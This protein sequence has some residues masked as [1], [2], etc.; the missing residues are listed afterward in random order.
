MSLA[1]LRQRDRDVTPT[2]HDWVQQPDLSTRLVH[3]GSQYL[4][5]I[6]APAA[7]SLVLEQESI[8][9]VS[10]MAPALIHQSNASTHSPPSLH[11][12]CTEATPTETSVSTGLAGHLA[13]YQ[14]LEEGHEG[15]LEMPH[16]NGRAPVFECAFWFLDC[17]YISR[18][19]EEWER[20]CLSHF[21]GEEPP[22]KVQCPLCDWTAHACEGGGHAAWAARM[23]HV[24][25]AHVM[26]GQTLRTSRP[27]F[28]LFEY[29][30]QQRLID[31]EDLKELKAGNHN[32]TRPPGNFVEMG[33][34]RRERGGRPH[35]TQHVRMTRQS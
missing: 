8:K 15:I 30:W 32:L 4:H 6:Q 18:N 1:A 19:Q 21:R 3:I 34:A 2:L 13:G 31:A 5:G 12:C 16:G 26:Y 35:R 33:G 9:S 22:L 28:A 24:A 10:S 14:L 25:S 11:S 23:H 7:D 29:L 17:G 20:H 27:D